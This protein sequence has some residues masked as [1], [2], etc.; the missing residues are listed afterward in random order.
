MTRNVKSSTVNDVA[1]QEPDR[2]F[3]RDEIL[4]ACVHHLSHL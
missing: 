2:S 1:S 4:K 3:K